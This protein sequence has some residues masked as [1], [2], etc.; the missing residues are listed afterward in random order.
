MY[1]YMLNLMSD[2]LLLRIVKKIRNLWYS[3]FS[4][5]LFGVSVELFTRKLL[6]EL[7]IGKP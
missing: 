4:M 3:T 1:Y 7:P 2:M 6:E 5:L